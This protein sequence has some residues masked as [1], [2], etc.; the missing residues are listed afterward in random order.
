MKYKR[1]RA[2]GLSTSDAIASVFSTVGVAMIITSVSLAV[3]FAVLS[4]SG[5]EI[6][7]ALG[8]QTSIIVIVAL[9]I[10]WFM[11]PPLLHIIDRGNGVKL[12]HEN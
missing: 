4:L 10:C 7:R 1:L 11:L 12:N 8:L 3:G 2:R 6:N 9:G 5:F